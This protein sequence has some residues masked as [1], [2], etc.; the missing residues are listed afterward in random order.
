M[1]M[2]TVTPLH[3]FL[4]RWSGTC[5]IWPWLM[6]AL[7]IN[8]PNSCIYYY[9]SVMYLIYHRNKLKA[10]QNKRKKKEKN[11]GREQERIPMVPCVSY[12]SCGA[13][14]ISVAKQERFHTIPACS[15]IDTWWMYP[16][17]HSIFVLLRKNWAKLIK[18]FPKSELCWYG[19][20]RA[21]IH[22]GSNG[23]MK[24][25]E[26]YLCKQTDNHE[27]AC[28]GAD[29]EY[30]RCDKRVHSYLRSTRMIAAQ[31]WAWRIARPIDWFTA[32]MQRF[33]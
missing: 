7:C 19:T 24:G 8:T 21:E 12:L 9:I 10:P 25:S 2:A 17:L 27:H 3:V 31:S 1:Y 32:R 33:W 20:T 29:H 15:S 16:L 26:K 28:D 22:F 13:V 23:M 18:A 4:C 6:R 11:M 14:L 30:E 5:I